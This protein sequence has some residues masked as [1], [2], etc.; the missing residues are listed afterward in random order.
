M[1]NEALEKRYR[2]EELSEQEEEMF[3]RHPGVGERLLGNVPR[4]GNV[5]RIVG[6]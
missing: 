2:G 5:A 1:P 4:L 3:A 6:R